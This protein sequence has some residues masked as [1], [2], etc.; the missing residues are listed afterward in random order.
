MG[1]RS[2]KRTSGVLVPC[3]AGR[4]RA[5]GD[6]KSPSLGSASGSGRSVD[7][8]GPGTQYRAPPSGI[9]RV[10]LPR[11]PPTCCKRVPPRL[12]N[13]R[14]QRLRRLYCAERPT[15]SARSPTPEASELRTGRSRRL[16][17]QKFSVCAGSKLLG[18]EPGG[19]ARLER[20]HARSHDRRRRVNWSDCCASQIGV[21]P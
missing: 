14:T 20:L 16:T 19:N 21:S 12:F 2:P 4:R 8:A 9:C 18:T 1:S 15:E 10:T 6:P 3:R 5:R 17:R 11:V 13:C 7:G